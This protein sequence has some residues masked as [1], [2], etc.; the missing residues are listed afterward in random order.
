MSLRRALVVPGLCALALVALFVADLCINTIEFEA[1]DGKIWFS[2][3]K[4]HFEL[5]GRMKHSYVAND[6]KPKALDC[7]VRSGDKFLG[8]LTVDIQPS[9]HTVGNEWGSENSIASGTL[10]DVAAWDTASTALHFDCRAHGQVKVMGTVP[11]SHTSNVRKSFPLTSSSD[12]SGTTLDGRPSASADRENVN[13]IFNVGVPLKKLLPESLKSLRIRAPSVEAEFRND[14][15]GSAWVASTEPVMFDA[16][17]HHSVP[18]HSTIGCEH[19]NGK[20]CLWAAPFAPL[21]G[22]VVKD[23]SLSL[24]IVPR[25]NN[26]LSKL[27][28]KHKIGFSA[29]SEGSMVGMKQQKSHEG[30]TKCMTATFDDT[31]SLMTCFQ[32]DDTH[33]YIGGVVRDDTTAKMME[34]YSMMRFD[35]V[36]DDFLVWDGYVTDTEEF[37]MNT[38][39][40]I[41][42][43]GMTLNVTADK[44]DGSERMGDIQG[45]LDWS[46]QFGFGITFSLEIDNIAA[47]ATASFDDANNGDFSLTIF[48]SGDAVGSLNISMSMTD[49][50]SGPTIDSTFSGA[51]GEPNADPF[52]QFSGSVFYNKATDAMTYS[53]TVSNTETPSEELFSISSGTMNWNIDTGLETN[54]GMTV[55]IGNE[56]LMSGSILFDMNMDDDTMRVRI[57]DHSDN[58]NTALADV[59]MLM[60]FDHGFAFGAD[61]LAEFGAFEDEQGHLDFDF[62]INLDTD[63]VSVDVKFDHGNQE[64]IQATAQ[65]HYSQATGLLLTFDAELEIEDELVGVGHAIIDFNTDDNYIRMLLTERDDE[66]RNLYLESEFGFHSLDGGLLYSKGIAY[67]GD[68][69]AAN[70]T[71]TLNYDSPSQLMFA[72]LHAVRDGETASDPAKDLMH[73]RMKVSWDTLIDEGFRIALEPKVIF[74]DTT[75]LDLGIDAQWNTEEKFMLFRGRETTGASAQEFKDGVFTPVVLDEFDSAEIVDTAVSFALR[76]TYDIDMDALKVDLGGRLQVAEYDEL[77]GTAVAAFSMDQDEIDISFD[78]NGDDGDFVIDAGVTGTGGFNAQNEYTWTVNGN[79]MVTEDDTTKEVF[80]IDGSIDASAPTNGAGTFGMSVTTEIDGNEFVTLT[81]PTV[82]VYDT[83]TGLEASGNLSIAVGGQTEVPAHGLTWSLDSDT[84]DNSLA[85][86]FNTHDDDGVVQDTVSTDWDYDFSVIWAIDGHVEGTVFTDGDTTID[87]H[88]ALTYDNMETELTVNAPDTAQG[89]VKEQYH[90]TNVISW[91]GNAVN[92]E[93]DV[94]ID[95]RVRMEDRFNNLTVNFDLDGPQ[96]DLTVSV[97]WVRT[98]ADHVELQGGL[99]WDAKTDDLGMGVNSALTVNDEDQFDLS[100]EI[101]FADEGINVR[102]IVHAE[103]PLREMIFIDGDAIWDVSNGLTIGSEVEM[104][105]EGNNTFTQESTFGYDGTEFELSTVS[106]I[107]V[108]GEQMVDINNVIDFDD[109]SI[110]M[111]MKFGEDTVFQLETD[112]DATYFPS[113]VPTISQSASLSSSITPTPSTT[114]APGSSR[115]RSETITPTFSP[116][117]TPSRSTTPSPSTSRS[118]SGSRT[119]SRSVTPTRTKSRSPSPSI[120]PTPSPVPVVNCQ[121]QL[122]GVTSSQFTPAVQTGFRRGVANGTGTTEENVIIDNFGDTNTTKRLFVFNKATAL[123]VEFHM[124]IK[125]EFAADSSQGL[126]AGSVVTKLQS[127]TEIVGKI[128]SEIATVDPSVQ[129]SSVEVKSV[130]VVAPPQPEEEDDDKDD[131]PST[132]IIAGVVGGLAGCCAVLALVCAVKKKKGGPAATATAEPPKAAA[133]ELPNLFPEDD[134]HEIVAK[135]TV[136]EPY[137]A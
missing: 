90:I 92:R 107:T 74:D 47:T 104:R 52:G 134:D 68:E 54:M 128:N 46:T 56:Q 1:R 39:Y 101:T 13:L 53:L 31:S 43:D 88:S 105:F 110:N 42:D 5:H 83:T 136:T 35:H 108:E 58:T 16:V 36:N 21:V 20:K 81:V 9:A 112:D 116:S 18:V 44:P 124:L 38:N 30:R 84:T 32:L 102:V 93:L 72:E 50:V 95:S 91:I 57:E 19:R 119:P 29:E 45:E 77:M 89:P 75:E 71:G 61:I 129:V 117:T 34:G 15:T 79:V 103:D 123:Q 48:D 100:G 65:A 80:T 12:G 49:G 97:D 10:S 115:S 86:G 118:S 41:H 130:Q 120:T 66:R 17:K 23:D 51:I 137:K 73:A 4:A 27:I 11:V 7:R 114:P 87:V 76:L 131:G 132:A 106:N 60:S 94:T 14:R 85:W 26:A 55:H 122:N 24:K 121:Y 99:T 59:N 69:H 22:T 125:Q 2:E 62:E 109:V 3:D 64:L 63:I 111:R 40:R 25:N 78:L 126:D 135:A 127:S 33:A 8:H 98:D 82:G 67:F 37:V 96:E 28:G 133:Q 6:V 113:V 70:L